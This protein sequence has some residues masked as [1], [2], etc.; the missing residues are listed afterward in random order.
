MF[1]DYGWDDAAALEALDAY[2]RAAPPPRSPLPPMPMQQQSTLLLPPPPPPPPFARLAAAAASADEDAWVPH[3]AFRPQ[4]RTDAV[5]A[6]S[7]HASAAAWGPWAAARAPRAADMP[8]DCGG[9]VGLGAPLE[10][11]EPP[12]Q[13][14]PPPQAYDPTSI[15]RWVYPTNV[16]ERAYQFEI[17]SIAVRQNTLVSLPTGLGKTLIAAV[18]MYNFWRW[19]PTGRCV[20]LAPT[21][22][23]VHQQVSAVRRVIGVPLCD[24]AELTGSMKVEERRAAWLRARLLFLTPQ[25]LQNDLESGS[26]PAHE[27][28][29]LVVDEA[30]KATGQHA[31]VKCACCWR[32]QSAA[33]CMLIAC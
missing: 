18:V 30:H 26:C 6:P 25:T 3:A 15:D 28:V 17:A 32:P 24:F 29:C 27:I 13:P 1:D 2:E 9:D 7:Q 8:A 23:L 31:Y 16:T 20:F 22:P 33:D 12:A 11:L 14:R 19:F 5:A 10:S 21:K 4:L